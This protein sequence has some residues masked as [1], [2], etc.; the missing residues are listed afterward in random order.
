MIQDPLD[1]GPPFSLGRGASFVLDLALL[2]FALGSLLIGL[3]LHLRRLI[4]ARAIERAQLAD[5]G[6]LREGQN[7]VLE[8]IIDSRG[9]TPPVRVRVTDFAHDVAPSGWLHGPRVV[10]AEAFDLETAHGTVRVEADARTFVAT[11]LVHERKD[12]SAWV[13]TAALERG[14]RIVA[15]GALRRERHDF[16]GYRGGAEGWTLRSPARG[17]LLLADEA[18]GN[19]Y[20]DRITVL[21]RFLRIAAPTW[22]VFHALCTSAFLVGTFTGTHTITYVTEWTFG[23][24][25]LLHTRT[26]DGLELD[27]TLKVSIATALHEE[28]VAIVPLLRS[29]WRSACYVGGQGWTSGPAILGGLLAALV[30]LGVLRHRLG[31]ATPWYDRPAPPEPTR[32]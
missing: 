10:L 6:P 16:A 20:D 32:A 19:R 11:E 5:Q 2:G 9:E 7:M 26:E 3:Y 4:A 14:T 28:S 24:P 25:E 30:A 17:R 13:R 18:L 15:Y 29:P 31:Q 27:T 12:A 22:L 1:F 23:S 21:Q 8:G